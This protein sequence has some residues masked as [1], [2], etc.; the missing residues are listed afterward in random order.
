MSQDNN[1]WY[2][3]QKSLHKLWEEGAPSKTNSGLDLRQGPLTANTISKIHQE[4][5]ICSQVDIAIFETLCV[6]GGIKWGKKGD[7]ED[8]QGLLV[9]ICLH[10]QVLNGFHKLN[11]FMGRQV[12]PVRNLKEALQKGKN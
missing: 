12:F 5:A 8:D 4:L 2:K 1:S 11:D 6:W 10:L 7:E 3:N 9:W